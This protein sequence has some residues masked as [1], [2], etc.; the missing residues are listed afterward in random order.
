MKILQYLSL[1]RL[2]NLGVMLFYRLEM[3]L[4]VFYVYRPMPFFGETL[5][6]LTCVMT[7]VDDRELAL[8][9]THLTLH[10]KPKA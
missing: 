3:I 8:Y 1:T 10:K 6:W 9:R 2:T 4:F 5:A 7:D